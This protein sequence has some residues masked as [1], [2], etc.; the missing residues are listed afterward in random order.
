MLLKKYKVYLLLVFSVLIRLNEVGKL[1]FVVG[2][3]LVIVSNYV[4]VGLFMLV[5]FKVKLNFLKE[6]VVLFFVFFSN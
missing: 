2:L 3:G 5:V 1:G 6:L 4:L